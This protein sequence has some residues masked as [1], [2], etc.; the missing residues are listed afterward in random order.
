MCDENHP[1]PQN[2]KINSF[3]IPL[4]LTNF[5]VCAL[6]CGAFTAQREQM[7]DDS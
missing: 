1:F 6:K 3:C 2:D 7:L 4:T 5:N